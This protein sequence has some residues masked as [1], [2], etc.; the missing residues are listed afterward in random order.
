MH[1]FNIINSEVMKQ[2]TN[3]QAKKK[4]YACVPAEKN[5]LIF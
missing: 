1:W 4:L 2:K 5:T 3:K